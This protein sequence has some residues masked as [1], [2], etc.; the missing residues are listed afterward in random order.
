MKI[1]FLLTSKVLYTPIYLVYA[2]MGL[3]IK[4]LYETIRYVLLTKTI[5]YR[6]CLKLDTIK[7]FVKLSAWYYASKYSYR[8]IEVWF[9]GDSEKSDVS[10]NLT[11]RNSWTP[12]TEGL[13]TMARGD[14]S[15]DHQWTCG[16]PLEKK[17]QANQQK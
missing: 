12:P 3:R 1:Y 4:F 17:K 6:T 16:V 8:L 13:C 5:I 15:T 2:I 7:Q 10:R 11:S 9:S 14:Y